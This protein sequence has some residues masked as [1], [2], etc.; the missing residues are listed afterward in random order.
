MERVQRTNTSNPTL[1][2]SLDGGG[3]KGVKLARN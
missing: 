2:A 3:G 1:M